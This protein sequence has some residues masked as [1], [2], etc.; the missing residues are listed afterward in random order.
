MP[1]PFSRR[2]RRC[3]DWPGRRWPFPSVSQSGLPQA[4]VANRRNCRSRAT[5]SLDRVHGEYGPIAWKNSTT[6]P[7]QPVMSAAISSKMASVALRAPIVDRLE[8]V[9]PL[10]GAG[11]EVRHQVR[12]QQVADIGNDPIVAGFD[13][14]N[15]PTYRRCCG[16]CTIAAWALMRLTSSRNGP[17]ALN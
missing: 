13:R 16:A 4:A 9:E 6:L 1:S 15:P 7:L 3:G 11:I 14:C 2:R 5:R 17:L 10:S 12:G 8:H